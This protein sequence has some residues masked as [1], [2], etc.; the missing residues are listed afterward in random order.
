MRTGDAL[1]VA[2][3]MLNDGLRVRAVMSVVAYRLQWVGQGALGMNCVDALCLFRQSHIC[4]SC[5]NG[6]ISRKHDE[7]IVNCEPNTGVIIRIVN[8]VMCLLK[9]QFELR[10]KMRVM[11][12][13]VGIGCVRL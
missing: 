5:L 1:C 11:H 9:E 6:P 3:I 2:N 12:G 4:S 13:N 7:I 8:W 10:D